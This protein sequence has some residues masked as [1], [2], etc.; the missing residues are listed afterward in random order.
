M[1]LKKLFIA[2][3]CML[4][5]CCGASSA[6]A[7]GKLVAAVLTSDMERYRDAYRSFLKALAAKGYEEGTVEVVTQTPNPDPI[8]W[9]NSVRK[10]DAIKPDLLVTFGAPVTLAAKQETS[11][12]PVVF[13]DVYGP[14]ET[15]ISRSMSQ[16][17][18]S[19]CG[20]SS[21]VPVATLIKAMGD[22]R[23]IRTLGVLYN[24]REAGSILQLKEVKRAAAQQGFAV[25]EANVPSAAG[26][27][28]ALTY[29][30]GRA[31]CLFVSESS[32]IGRGFD[33]IV[34]KATDA[35]VAV[36]SLTPGSSE[37]GALVSL[38]I[39]PTE[40]GQ[41]AADYASKILSGRRPG[42]LPVYTPRKV[43]LVLNMG[44][45]R[46]LDLHVPFKALS[47]ATRVIK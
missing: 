46:T 6:S 42:E 26:L 32:V 4:C 23:P 36:I 39:S 38:E 10:F 12:I 11:G 47:A 3:T 24:T 27:D 16:A 13:V 44:V 14:V 40:Q 41:L 17:G 31:D 25:V 22:I 34:R 21:K 30:L 9:A 33:R 37:R 2:L 35:R 5:L 20:V 43:D 45:A 29:L 19:L 8:S 7:A 18:G 28:T 1:A 15:G